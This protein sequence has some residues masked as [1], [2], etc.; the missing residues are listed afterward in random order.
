[1]AQR[2][3]ATAAVLAAAALVAACGARLDET[4][5][6]AGQAAA[7]GTGVDGV[8]RPAATS[9][10]V[11]AQSTVAAGPTH[12]GAPAPGVAGAPAPGGAAPPPGAGGAPCTPQGA[13]DVGID[14]SSVTVGQV[15]TISGPVPGLSRTAVNGVRAYVAYKNSQGGVCGRELRL[16]NGDDRLDSGQNRAEHAR[17]MERVFAFVG[18][19]SVVDDG[20]A[21]VLNGTNVPDVGLSISNARVELANNFSS[22][23]VALEGSGFV[24]IL[25]HVKATYGVTSAGVVWGAQAVS[26]ARAQGFIADLNRLGMRVVVQKEVQITE[27]NYVPVAQELENAGAELVITTL[28]ITGIARLAQALEQ[29]GYKPKVPF[30]GAQSYG[31]QLINLAGSAAEGAI[32]GL[33]HPIIEEVGT[34]N[35]GLDTFVEWYE[36]VNPGQPIDFFSFQGW[37]ATDMFAD[38]LLAAGPAPTRDSVLAALRQQTR[39]DADGLVAPFNPA[40]KVGT[41]CFLIVTVKDGRW[42]R[43]FPESGGFHC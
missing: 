28:E 20:G 36:R 5:L 26:R 24:E 39:F 8:S 29:V 15:N 10:T 37:V 9:T 30:Y 11:A 4:Q 27:S 14:A 1:M 35:A 38:A 19:W 23:P 25:E 41:S 16:V 33:N 43:V 31:E 6:A 13:S 22:N 7:T 34:G 18:G 17:L 21:S 42:Q 40:Q 12:A 32:L 2:R 3:L